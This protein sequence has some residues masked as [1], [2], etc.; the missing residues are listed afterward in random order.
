MCENIIDELMRKVISAISASSNGLTFDELRDALEREGVY[1]DATCLRKTV[2]QMLR[3]NKI[4]K[5]FS[6]KKRNKFV[7][8]ISC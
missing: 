2:S 4:M 3:E 1:I 8:K 7:F 5:C 6:E